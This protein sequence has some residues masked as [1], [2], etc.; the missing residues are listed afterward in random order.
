M[1]NLSDDE[2]DT[3]VGIIQSASSRMG[4]SVSDVVSGKISPRSSIARRIAIAD[5]EEIF[6]A[7][8]VDDLADIF[9]VSASTIRNSAYRS[10]E[11]AVEAPPLNKEPIDTYVHV[12]RCHR[13]EP[14]APLLPALPVRREPLRNGTD[15][16]ASF[17]GDPAP[18]RSALDQKRAG[19]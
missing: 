19:Q 13:S 11:R 12:P 18:G 9:G 16:T 2:L 17:C 8:S 15:I 3:I 14:M 4:C 6:P 5:I 1:R 7:L 10:R